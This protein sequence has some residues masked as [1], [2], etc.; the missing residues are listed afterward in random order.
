MFD[1]RRQIADLEAEIERLSASAERCR[2]IML[3]S[4]VAAGA[5]CVLLVALGVGLLR[6]QPAAFLVALTAV[7]AGLALLGTH[8]STLDELVETLKAREALRSR[9]IDGLELR[10]VDAG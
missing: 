8:A 5:G 2:K 1:Q 10:V 3:V 9:M 6:F 7:L 4:K